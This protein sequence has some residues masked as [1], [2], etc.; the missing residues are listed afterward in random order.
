[1]RAL[2]LKYVGVFSR[3]EYDVGLTSL[4]QYKLELK[5]PSLPPVC[6]SLRQHPLAYLDEIDRQVD[7]LLNAGLI[8]PCNSA[9]ASN[10]VLVRKRGQPCE[11]VKFLLLW[12]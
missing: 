1:V 5:D 9:W 10:L 11:P 2:L 12:I 7:Q 8:T 4:A 6:E 3:H